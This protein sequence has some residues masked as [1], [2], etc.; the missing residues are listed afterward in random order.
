MNG[1]MWP[2]VVMSHRNSCTS[3]YRD[4]GKGRERATGPG[5]IRVWCTKPAYGG[6]GVHPISALEFNK[7]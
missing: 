3:A 6:C 2:I 1:G 4:R 5:G 7:E